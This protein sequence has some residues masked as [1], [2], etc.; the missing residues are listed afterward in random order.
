M[1]SMANFQSSFV[2]QFMNELRP[3][4]GG[5]RHP[6]S[7]WN[8][9]NPWCLQSHGIPG[10]M[11]W[12]WNP[13]PSLG[14]QTSV[15]TRPGRKLCVPWGKVLPHMAASALTSHVFGPAK[16]VFDAGGEFA[17]KITYSDRSIRNL[18]RSIRQIHVYIQCNF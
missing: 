18:D 10:S 13:G 16:L 4:P 6:R 17:G 1:A 12:A 7:P 11:G 3:G 15:K 2:A 9:L 14:V 8:L 5:P